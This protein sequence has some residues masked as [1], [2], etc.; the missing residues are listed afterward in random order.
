MAAPK[1]TR[2]SLLIGSYMIR[3][4]MII[5]AQRRSVS[6]GP[7]THDHSSISA[8]GLLRIYDVL[9]TED[10][11]VWLDLQVMYDSD[12]QPPSG[13]LKQ[14]RH[15]LIFPKCRGKETDTTGRVPSSS[16]LHSLCLTVK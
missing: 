4:R 8:L 1:K 14:D 10:G 6:S 7:F 5:E 12:H 16:P 3:P 11:K 15:L 9:L 2:T 13:Q